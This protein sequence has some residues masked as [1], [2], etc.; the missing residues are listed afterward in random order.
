MAKGRTL[1]VP[2][3]LA[4][5]LALAGALGFGPGFGGAAGAK[6]V[7]DVSPSCEP[8]DP[9]PEEAI[10]CKDSRLG[11]ALAEA[12]RAGAK[13][14]KLFTDGCDLSGGPPEP[15]GIPVDVVLRP[16]RDNIAVLGVR[17][18]GRIPVG[19]DFAVEIALGLRDHAATVG[20]REPVLETYVFGFD[21]Q[22]YGELAEVFP[23]RLLR[24]ERKFPSL[25]ALQAQIAADRDAAQAFLATVAAL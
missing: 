16:R 6:E 8:P 14:V 24:A 22:V 5:L 2:G 18:P 13:K 4:L 1:L 3:A 7:V 9:I 25:A 20:G 23:L 10:L 21:A 17:A 15:P 12:R 11:A 19:T